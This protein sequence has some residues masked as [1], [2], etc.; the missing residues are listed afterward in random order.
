[1]ADSSVAFPPF[2]QL[3]DAHVAHMAPGYG[4]RT[5]GRLLRR[6]LLA[7]IRAPCHE[8]IHCV[9]HVAKQVDNS[10]RCGGASWSAE[11]DASLPA[12]T[13]F[14]QMYRYAVG[15]DALPA[16][17][18][19]V[20]TDDADGKADGD[21]TRDKPKGEAEVDAEG[22][23]LDADMLELGYNFSIRNSSQEAILEM[24]SVLAGG[25]AAL[26]LARCHVFS[27]RALK[28]LSEK[29]QEAFCE[30]RE[31]FGLSVR[32]HVAW[33]VPHYEY[34]LLMGRFSS[35]HFIS[36]CIPLFSFPPFL[37]LTTP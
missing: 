34:I 26:A 15:A 31:S 36:L 27:E 13:I 9:Q 16:D 37:L 32:S 8:M 29:D 25:I 12:H 10:G 22:G 2:D 19:D 5:R 7:L 6:F 17:I 20:V 1:M 23:G 14:W 33:G 28:V 30:W 24:K 11:H 18:E 4:S 3:T 35:M 21:V